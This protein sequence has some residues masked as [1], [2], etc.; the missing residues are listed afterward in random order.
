MDIKD[1][2]TKL[3]E[4][5]LNGQ[6]L[7]AFEEFYHENIVMSENGRDERVGKRANREFEKDFFGKITAFNGAEVK[8]VA[9]AD[10]LSTVEMFMDYEHSE[11]G[12]KVFTQV[13]VQEWK[14]GLII[15]ETFYHG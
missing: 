7:E 11:W 1:K 2:V 13:A 6:A 15:R 14:D 12:H 4:M 8:N 10:N 9:F 3:N 5:I